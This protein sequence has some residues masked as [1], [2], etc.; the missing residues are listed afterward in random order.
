MFTCTLKKHPY[1]ALIFFLVKII[2]KLKNPFF[3]LKIIKKPHL[4]DPAQVYSKS[5]VLVEYRE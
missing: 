2:F 5:K 1:K 3:F 4:N